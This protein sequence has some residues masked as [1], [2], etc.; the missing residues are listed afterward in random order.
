ML[1]D[2]HKLTQFYFT[3]KNHSNNA[4]LAEMIVT[5]VNICKGSLCHH[6]L[7]KLLLGLQKNLSVSLTDRFTS[8][9]FMFCTGCVLVFSIYLCFIGKLCSFHMIWYSSWKLI[10]RLFFLRNHKSNIILSFRYTFLWGEL[11]TLIVP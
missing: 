10:D 2:N 7:I 8:L 11:E 1:T 3:T 4:V 9:P 6:W 5:I